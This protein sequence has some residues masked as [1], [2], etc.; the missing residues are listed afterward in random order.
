MSSRAFRSVVRRREHYERHQPEARAR[1]GLL[2]KKKDYVVRAKNF[3]LREKRISALKARA[4]NKNPDEFYFGMTSSKTKGGVHEKTKAADKAKPELT[5]ELLAVMQTQDARY[6][7]TLVAAEE[8]KIARLAATLH[9]PPE[10]AAAAGGKGKHTVFVENSE[11]AA[12]FD[13][14]TYFDVE[15]AALLKVH[16]RPRKSSAAAA[17]AA[18][19]TVSG[20]S[21]SGVGP[22][23]A[24]LGGSSRAERR[25]AP[26]SAAYAELAER[27]ARVSQLASVGAHMDVRRAL[28]KPGK[29]T[30]V[31]DAK[32]GKP[33][34]YK[35]R[36]ERK[37]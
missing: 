3:H 20:R 24:K 27:R 15:P 33:A 2:E 7:G 12:D 5:K 10:T 11:D 6:V 14:A 16:N 9:L 22:K 23:G 13:A 31:A 30:K 17:A 32:D 34:Q 37:R 1:F 26:A 25:A 19:A 4:D 35:W 28:Q 8:K 36:A 29:R 21:G 18:A